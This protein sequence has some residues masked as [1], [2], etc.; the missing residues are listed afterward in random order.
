M[1]SDAELDRLGKARD[2]AYERLRG[3]RAERKH[4]GEACTR[5]HAEVDDAFRVQQRAYEDNQYRWTQHQSFMQD[6]SRKIQFWR[7]ES[8][9]C[10]TAMVSS[11]QESQRCWDMGD[12]PGAK[13]WSEDA[14]RHQAE[15]RNAKEQAAYWVQQS[16]NAKYRFEQDG[17]A[18]GQAKART[19][20][21][22]SELANAVTKLNAAKADVARLETEFESARSAFQHRLD[23]LK[24]A[25]GERSQRVERE[26]AQEGFRVQ[27]AKELANAQRGRDFQFGAKESDVQVKVKAGWDRNHDMPCTDVLIFV[28]GVRGHHH[29]VIGEDGRVFIDEWRDK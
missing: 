24:K 4:L 10:H 27:R 1:G 19:A 6:C 12:K 18:V 23:S 29:T 5:L 7:G 15:M 25:S 14:K 22:R 2:A 28:K 13:S 26:R 8:D 9:R 21:K 11:F 17:D 20:A 3:A 16:R